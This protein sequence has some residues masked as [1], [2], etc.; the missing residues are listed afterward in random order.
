[1]QI[2]GLAEA[3]SRAWMGTIWPSS[4]VTPGH[5]LYFATRR[6]VSVRGC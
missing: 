3:E 2:G 6:D 1:M 5:A 4:I